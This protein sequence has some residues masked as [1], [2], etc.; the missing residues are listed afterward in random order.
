MKAL[1]FQKFGSPEVLAIEEAP[2]PVAGEGETL[3]RVRAASVNPSDVKNVAGRFKATTLP[4]TP[5]RDFA[6]IVAGGKGVL[7]EEVWG[8]AP[9]AGVTHDGVQAEY[10]VVP[11]EILTRK[12][13]N[14][15]LEQAA[16]I[17]VPFITAW[18]TVVQ[19]ARLKAGETILITGAAG[20]VGQ[21][22]VQI[23]RSLKARVLGAD[24]KAGRVAGA[25]AVID[26][27]SEDLRERTLALT[28]GKG[29]NVVLDTVGGPAFEP[30]LRSLAK[31]GRQIVITSVADP[32][33]S[34][35]LVDFYHNASHLIG[36]DTM[37]LTAGEV[38]EIEAALNRA[39]EAGT[40]TPPDVEAIPFEKAVDAYLKVES[41]SVTAKQVLTL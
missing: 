12:P 40:L 21:A 23:A 24:R 1:R 6:G 13:R 5:G 26:M 38:A 28:G 22:A 34:S 2:K 33:V 3:V 9:G 19:A 8:S 25:D 36:V 7:G 32:R 41:G 17:G 20:A 31:G 30:A 15:S 27:S 39:F 37:A 35:N 11:S 14:V 10:C 18:A 4:R 29:A 16:A